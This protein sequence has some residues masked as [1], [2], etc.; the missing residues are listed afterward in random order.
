MLLLELPSGKGRL[1]ELLKVPRDDLFPDPRLYAE[2]WNMLGFALLGSRS[3]PTHPRGASQLSDEES[4]T[5]EPIEE[6]E[7]AAPIGLFND[8]QSEGVEWAEL[9]L[10]SK[11]VIFTVAE[12]VEK[13][14]DDAARYAKVSSRIGAAGK[15]L[16]V[17]RGVDEMSEAYQSEMNATD[18]TLTMADI[19]IA[20]ISELFSVGLLLDSWK[21]QM[22]YLHGNGDLKSSNSVYY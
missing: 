12:W 14:P 16:M 13:D 19:A 3:L 9:W 1:S 20:T 18:K 5:Q 4:K 8:Q 22:I 10:S 2:E 7:S 6:T 15:A 17:V 11:E 21:L